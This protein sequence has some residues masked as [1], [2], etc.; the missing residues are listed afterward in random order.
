MTAFTLTP[1]GAKSTARPLARELTAPLIAA[2]TCANSEE[3]LHNENCGISRTAVSGFGFK[4][5]EPPVMVYEPP[6]L[7]ALYLAIA[8]AIVIRGGNGD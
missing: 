1:K 8:N 4:L 5:K 3:I 6:D 2:P 7:T